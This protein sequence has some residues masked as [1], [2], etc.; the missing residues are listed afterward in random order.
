MEK[1]IMV[2]METAKDNFI[3]QDSFSKARSMISRYN[4]IYCLTNNDVVMDI[5][6]KIDIN[7]KIHYLESFLDAEYSKDALLVF[8]L[9]SDI[10]IKE[11]SCVTHNKYT[12][13]FYRPIFWYQDK[14]LEDY[15]KLFLKGINGGI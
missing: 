1:N 4:E 6:K 13:D 8:A 15:R 7:N 2:L 14:D 3:I 11:T 12:P 10:C 9:R 5:C